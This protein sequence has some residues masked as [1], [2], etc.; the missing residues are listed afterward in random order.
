MAGKV[1]AIPAGYR[2]YDRTSGIVGSLLATSGTR[3]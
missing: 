3:R 2:R 1:N